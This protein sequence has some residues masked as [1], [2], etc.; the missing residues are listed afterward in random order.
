[1]GEHFT[2]ADIALYASTHVAP[3]GGV[4]LERYP[5]IR[6]WLKRVEQQPRH[7]PITAR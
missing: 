1:V 5:T 2:L 4:A 7:A 3:Q 6:A